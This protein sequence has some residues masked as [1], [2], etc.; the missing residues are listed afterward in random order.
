MIVIN[1]EE[2][3]PSLERIIDW[4]DYYEANYSLINENQTELNIETIE[5]SNSSFIVKE[6]H[7]D[8]S[9]CKIYWNRRSNPIKIRTHNKSI[10]AP[11]QELS[12]LNDFFNLILEENAVNRYQDNFTNKL[13]NLYI[14]KKLGINIPNT[15]ITQQKK[16]LINFYDEHNG[17][18]INKAIDSISL[19][20]PKK[21]G[22][23]TTLV[24]ESEIKNCEEN[25]LPSLFQECL[26]K[27]YEI[28]SFY[29]HGNFYS[30]AIFSQQDELTRIDFRN[31]NYNKPNRCVS[32]KLPKYIE[33]K[34]HQLMCVL[35]L[36]TG[37][38]DL[39][40][41]NGNEYYFLE[42]NP[43]GMFSAL[44]WPLNY[45]IEKDIATHLVKIANQYAT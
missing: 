8:L 12:Y 28:R 26:S 44:T 33:D 34:L 29:F 6:E 38:I 41:T 39:I 13:Y 20:S 3:D 40:F 45:S 32:Y 27:Q 35:K 9:N 10:T 21:E 25:F 7:M 4:L 18:I 37:S 1:I 42:V 30:M 16:K 19:F 23:Y 14:S 15:I 2:A 5:L 36:N 22:R 31:Y 17:R 43:V 24:E 11:Q